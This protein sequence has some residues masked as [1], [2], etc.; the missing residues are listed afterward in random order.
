MARSAAGHQKNGER[1]KSMRDFVTHVP[2]ADGDATA[3]WPAAH[4]HVVQ[5]RA[6]PTYPAPSRIKVLHVITRFWAGAGHSTL[7]SAEGMDPERYEVWVAGVPGGYLWDQA[8]ASG[9]RAVE[10]PGFRE[11]ITPQDALVLWRLVRLIRRERFTIVH[12]HSGKGGFLGRLAAW[13]CR[14]PVVVHSYHG[15]SFH[16]FMPRLRYRVYHA[17]ERVTRSFTDTFLAES[18]LLAREIIE[19]RLAPPGAVEVVPTAVDLESIPPDF[20]PAA[21]EAL[22]VSSRTDLVGTVGRIDSQKAPLDFVRMA[23]AVH[24]AHPNTEF[25]MVGDGP[26]ADAVRQLAAQLGVEVRITGWRPDAAQLVAGLDIFAITSLYEGLGRAL[27]EALAAAR[28]VVA[29]AVNGVPDLV[30][31]G[32]TGLL[33]PP[34]D[35]DGM[36]EAVGWLLDHPN[37]A[38]EMGRQG[39]SHVRTVFG[40]E[41]MCAAI[42]ACYRRMLS[43]R[44]MQPPAA[45][46]ASESHG[47]ESWPRR[48]RI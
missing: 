26:L 48:G 14:T 12:T 2:G 22:G 21:R 32:A 25:M 10:I 30:E 5:P 7:M 46:A 40:P 3:D 18:P 9:V 24:A 13:L 47:R 43:L 45:S 1:L 41:T 6:L 15:L 16:P 39:R 4:A 33:G 17:L 35:P 20:D 36:A 23:A 19:H 8:R 44:A 27:T 31:H 11:V 38:A 28:P 29:T 42:D 34:R 37:E